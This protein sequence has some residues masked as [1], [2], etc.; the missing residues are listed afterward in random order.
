MFVDML[1]EKQILSLYKLLVYMANA[2]GDVSIEEKSYINKF[3]KTYNLEDFDQDPCIISID[4]CLTEMDSKKAK[5]I[6]LMELVS[7]S[8]QDGHF[9][10]FEQK[11]YR[12][13]ACKFGFSRSLKL[14]L[15]IESFV[16][17]Q[18]DL[19]FEGESLVS[20]NIN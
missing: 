10:D 14:L 17:K 3:K 6:T 7:L 13:I 16:R 18:F 4:E 19:R 8:Y 1:S 15:D 5:I 12:D 20:R 9:C 2:D 11:I